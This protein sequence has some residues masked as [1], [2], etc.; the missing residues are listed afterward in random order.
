MRNI[1]LLISAALFA[2]CADDSATIQTSTPPVNFVELTK[3]K[4]VH[5]DSFLIEDGTYYAD[6]TIYDFI[7]EDSVK[8]TTQISRIRQYFDFGGE[9]AYQVTPINYVNTKGYEILD[10]E[11]KLLLSQWE[12]IIYQEGPKVEKGYDYVYV[13]ELTGTSMILDGNRGVQKFKPIPK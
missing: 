4:W 1:L 9:I 10:A 13:R 11:S 5:L 2:A 8:L 12:T 7:T 3:Y 6:S